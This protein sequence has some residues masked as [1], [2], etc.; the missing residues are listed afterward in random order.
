MI[1]QNLDGIIG[2]VCNGVNNAITWEECASDIESTI[3]VFVGIYVLLV[4]LV[5]GFLV[6]ILYYYA[7]EAK[8]EVHHGGSYNQLQ[9]HHG[10]SN[11]HHSDKVG[12]GNTMH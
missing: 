12:H 10:R 8:E 9:G 5:R 6:R 2:R 11:S 3:W 1:T 7:E 4:I